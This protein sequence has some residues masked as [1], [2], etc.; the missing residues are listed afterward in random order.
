VGTTSGKGPATRLPQLSRASLG[1]E[2]AEDLVEPPA[3]L[4]VGDHSPGVSICET[5]TD[6]REEALMVLRLRLLLGQPENPGEPSRSS[7]AGGIVSFRHAA[8]PAVARLSRMIR[9]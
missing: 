8:L 5:A 7:P 3:E 4:L 2:G 1:T 9:G 6:R